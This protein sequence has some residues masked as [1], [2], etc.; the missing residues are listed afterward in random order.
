MSQKR[1]DEP[2]NTNSEAQNAKFGLGTRFD[3]L[4]E[5]VW[6][7]RT[8]EALR[9]MPFG[10]SG[11]WAPQARPDRGG[12]PGERVPHL[13]SGVLLMSPYVVR[14]FPARD[15]AAISRY[16]NSLPRVLWG[17]NP[18]RPAKL[19]P[20][21][22]I[23]SYQTVPGYPLR[24]IILSPTSD[25]KYAKYR[26][27][28]MVMRLMTVALQTLVSRARVSWSR[29]SLAPPSRN[30][31]LQIHVSW[32]RASGTE[33]VAV[34]QLIRHLCR[35]PQGANLYG[36]MAPGANYMGGKRRSNA[37]RARS[38]DTV[39][40]AQKHFFTRQRFD[41]F[42]KG[43]SG[44][45]QPGGR[46]SAHGP[47]ATAL[48]IGLSHARPQPGTRPDVQNNAP[49]P[50]DADTPQRMRPEC[51]R[52][53]SHTRSSSASGSRSSKVLEALDTTEPLAMRAAMKK[54]L[55]IPDLAGLSTHRLHAESV[56]EDH[57]QKSERRPEACET[58]VQGQARRRMKGLKIIAADTK[59]KTLWRPYSPSPHTHKLSTSN[60]YPIISLSS[61]SAGFAH[62]SSQYLI[63]EQNTVREPLPSTKHF[64]L[65]DN[66]YDYEDPWAAIGVILGFEDA[67]AANMAEASFYAQ[68]PADY[69]PPDSN[70]VHPAPPSDPIPPAVHT[71]NSSGPFSSQY[72]DESPVNTRISAQNSERSD[73]SPTTNFSHSVRRAIHANFN[74]DELSPTH[75]HL[76]RFKFPSS[77]PSLTNAR[78]N[79]HSTPGFGAHE[80][81]VDNAN[82]S[83]DTPHANSGPNRSNLKLPLTVFPA[84]D[85]PSLKFCDS[86][87]ESNARA[88]HTPD[89]SP[90]SAFCLANG[91]SPPAG[92]YDYLAAFRLDRSLRAQLEESRAATAYY[93]RDDDHCNGS[94]ESGDFQPDFCSAGQRHTTTTQL[95]APVNVTLQSPFSPR[96]R[97]GKAQPEPAAAEAEAD[98]LTL[99][100][101]FCLV[102]SSQPHHSPILDS[103]AVPAAP[104]LANIVSPGRER[105]GDGDGD[106]DGDGGMPV[107]PLGSPVQAAPL[108]QEW[109]TLSA[110]SRTP[111]RGRGHGGS[112]LFELG[113]AA[114]RDARSQW[115]VGDVLDEYP[116]AEESLAVDAA[117]G[118][119]HWQTQHL[120]LV[121]SAAPACPDGTDVPGS[122][123]LSGRERS[124]R[125]FEDLSGRERY[126]GDISLFADDVDELESDD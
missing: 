33:A 106:G 43:L 2:K 67:Q 78:R 15:L 89:P 35:R 51:S 32:G 47:R 46:A 103:C 20:S 34:L 1:A 27:I 23:I 5:P 87:A 107:A 12:G 49:H 41:V 74:S 111:Q 16:Y 112:A 14:P 60:Q 75:A 36:T 71:E 31:K 22:L 4:E 120:E 104:R 45:S 114:G 24:Q 79:T 8:V 96:E 25:F 9:M 69:V 70:I 63:S 116:D 58:L 52:E 56:A 118:G 42:S 37:A 53:R 68:A 29:I 73:L 100:T 59:R 44:R 6:V 90:A 99:H 39:A 64:F 28:K 18:N 115:P 81:A 108:G 92:D 101:R 93:A 91:S 124:A 119:A 86:Q 110:T 80:L 97:E 11:P 88:L 123:D 13:L 72:S 84:I 117:V 82:C 40:R 38:K 21:N 10:K 113:R 122:E 54:I 76:T 85:D 50:F 48:D 109:L 62:D 17:W 102:R 66:L 83:S 7:I 57:T 61:H 26:P 105:A 95:S 55:S 65:R 77:T 98:S 94:D 126:F 3:G 30:P 19:V 125:I 121:D